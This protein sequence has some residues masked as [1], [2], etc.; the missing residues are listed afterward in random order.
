MENRQ[1]EVRRIF[2]EAPAPAT[3]RFPL[4]GEN[5]FKLWMILG[6]PAGTSQ[7]D[8]NPYIGRL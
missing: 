4:Q 1:Q 6:C 5:V 8:H 7:M 2:T 3:P